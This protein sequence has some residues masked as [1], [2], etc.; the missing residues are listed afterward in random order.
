VLIMGLILSLS[1]SA[2][3]LSMTDQ[4]RSDPQESATLWPGGPARRAMPD[5][6]VAIDQPAREAALRQPPALTPGL[7]DR[8]EEQYGI[9]CS[10]CHGARG[11]G[12]GPVVRR[13]FPPP[14]SYRDP[15]LM[16]APPSYV[17]D[18]I[19]HGHGVMYSYADRVEPADRWAIAAYVKALQRAPAVRR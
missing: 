11:D 14:P 9:F 19:T 17:V 1:L 4:Q 5:G 15:R 16:A 8:G 12:D 3:D 10:V 18:V 13:G 6:T 7:L 2:C